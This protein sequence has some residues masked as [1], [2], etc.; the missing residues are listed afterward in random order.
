MPNSMTFKIDTLSLLQ[1]DKTFASLAEKYQS[2]EGVS[3]IGFTFHATTPLINMKA[4]SITPAVMAA[5][6]QSAVDCMVDFEHHAE[7]LPI[8]RD[9]DDIGTEVVGHMKEIIF[10]DI[11]DPDDEDAWIY[12]PYIPREPILTRGVMVLYTRIAKVRYIANEINAGAPWYF[13]LEIGE[14]VTPPAIW[15]EA[16][17]DNPEHQIIPWSDAPE[18]LRSIAGRPQMMEYNG[19]RV[20]YLMGGA[21]GRVSFVGGAITRNPAGFE[22]R[23]PGNAL[24]FI[25]SADGVIQDIKSISA[26]WTPAYEN[27]LPDSS[28]AVIEE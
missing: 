23:A 10:G 8:P 24:Q 3:Y 7:D 21:E 17:D 14:D 25:A 1:D 6:Y 9:D 12:P 15:L 28:F 20:S 16:N 19:R 11:P 5:S 18:D 22:Q 27:S 4:M 13:S 2:H 26:G